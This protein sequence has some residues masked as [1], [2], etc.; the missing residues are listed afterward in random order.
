M[1]RRKNVVVQD[2]VNGWE[3]SLFTLVSLLGFY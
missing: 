2:G 1:K 3:F